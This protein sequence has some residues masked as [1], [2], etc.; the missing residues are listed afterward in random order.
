M[1]VVEALR[2]GNRENHSYV[3]GVYESMRVAAVAA[4]AEEYHRGGKY[5][6]Y[7]TQHSVDTIDIEK[8]QHLMTKCLPNPEYLENEIEFIIKRSK[9]EFINE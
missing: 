5:E 6:C 2:M 7:I 8:S 9:A 4:L 1:Y 3:V